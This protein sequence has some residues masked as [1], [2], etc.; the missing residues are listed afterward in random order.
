MY[1]DKNAIKNIGVYDDYAPSEREETDTEGLLSPFTFL[2]FAV[3]L[4]L[5]GI[6]TLFSAS[7]DSALRG[8]KAFYSLFMKQTLA[9]VVGICAGTGVAFLSQNILRR[10][11]FLFSAVYL[12]LFLVTVF[13]TSASPSFMYTSVMGMCGCMAVLLVLSDLVPRILSHE[14]RGLSLIGLVL[15]VVFFLVSEA[16]I[17]GSG[18]YIVTF[19]VIVS[20]LS[21]L[22]VR[23]SYIL[24][25]TITAVIVLAFLTLSSTKL[26]SSFTSSLFP[27]SDT[28]YYSSALHLS[29]N[30]I[31]EGG[32][33]GVG[34]GNGL[35]KLGLIDDVEGEFIYASLSEETGMV[36]TIIII[37]CLLMILIIAVRSSSRAYR[38]NEYFIASL[39]LGGAVLL[40]FTILLNML[41]VSGLLPV[42]GVPLLLFSYNPVNESLSVIL[43][44]LLYKCIFRMGR[45]KDI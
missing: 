43:L 11:H 44:C 42:E 45:E 12:I 29:E 1:E 14:K 8:E 28:S 39:T 34:I 38:R 6:V 2:C 10:M 7:Y 41:Y 17:C 30:A 13:I 23:R 19:L 5:F 18:W 33:I 35:Y 9:L 27:L 24:Y 26:L 21:C 20:S 36:G 37:F 31:T 32:F 3:I 16:L 15:A 40:S 25:F 22:K 4:A